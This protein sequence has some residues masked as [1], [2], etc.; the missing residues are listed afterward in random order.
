[1]TEA[2]AASRRVWPLDERMRMI[3]QIVH[4]KRPVT[5]VAKE[6]KINPTMLY[7]WKTQFLRGESLEPG[8]PGNK[9]KSKH[10]KPAK[11]APQPTAIVQA[12]APGSLLANATTRTH[13]LDLELQRLRAENKRLRVALKALILEGD[14]L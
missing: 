4:E 14:E 11:A 9:K 3:R 2:A 5:E 6:N 12:P 10:K 7:N 8:K 1:M 13:A